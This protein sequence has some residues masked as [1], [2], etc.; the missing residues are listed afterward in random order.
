MKKEEL[1]S[2]GSFDT[3]AAGPVSLEV[4][5]PIFTDSNLLKTPITMVKEKNKE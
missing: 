5:T 3:L 4:K 2:D 1:K